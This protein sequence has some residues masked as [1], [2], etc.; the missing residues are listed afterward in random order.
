MVHKGENPHFTLC[1]FIQKKV[2]SPKTSLYSETGVNI[3]CTHIT[4][5]SSNHN[6]VLINT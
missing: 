6:Y 1:R 2:V 4:M 3:V 5:F